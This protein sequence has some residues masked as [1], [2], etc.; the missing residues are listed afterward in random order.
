MNLLKRVKIMIE[1]LKEILKKENIEY[2]YVVKASSG[3]TCSVYVV[4]EEYIVKLSNNSD[5]VGKIQKEVSFYTNFKANFIPK[6]ISSGEYGEY[7]YAIIT[8]IQGKSLF[9]VW[10]FLTEEKREDC[11]S[12]ICDILRILHK[13]NKSILPNK[14]VNEDFL[15]DLKKSLFLKLGKIGEKAQSVEKYIEE[16]FEELFETKIYSMIYNDAHFDNFLYNEG[17][18]YLIDFDRIEYA[19]IDYELLIFKTMC[20]YPT[21]FASERNESLVHDEDFSNIYSYFKKYYPDIFKIKHL[22]E[23]VYIYQFDYYIRIP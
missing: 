3:F 19:L 2:K 12:Q 4:D 10:H 17:K 9:D 5:V 20:D 23:R 1:I 18:V 16:N 13:Q 22:D 14:F 7:K 15:F 21:K 8:K 6:L 11:I